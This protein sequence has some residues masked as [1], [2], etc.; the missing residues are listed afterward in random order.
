MY[1]VNW[2]QPSIERAVGEHRHWR[3]VPAHLAEQRITPDSSRTGGRTAPWSHRLWLMTFQ[4]V[5]LERSVI[6]RTPFTG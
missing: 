3:A 4:I 1:A 5:M 2:Y 6:Q